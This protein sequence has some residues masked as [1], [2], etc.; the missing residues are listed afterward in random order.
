MAEVE[1]ALKNSTDEKGDDFK[2]EHQSSPTYQQQQTEEELKEMPIS[3]N[4]ISKIQ[5][6]SNQHVSVMVKTSLD[7]MNNERLNEN[8]EVIIEYF[9][10]SKIDGVTLNDMKKREF[11]AP[12]VAKC[13]GNAKLNG[14]LMNLFAKLKQFD[15]NK[16]LNDMED[17]K[18]Q[19]E[20]TVIS[21][22]TIKSIRLRQKQEAKKGNWSGEI[23]WDGIAYIDQCKKDHILFILN[24][25]L[26]LMDDKQLNEIR[27]SI[28]KYFQNNNI[29]GDAWSD[30][31]RKE[32]AAKIIDY[33]GSNKKSLTRP[34]L[35]LYKGINQFDPHQ[36]HNTD[37]QQEE[38]EEQKYGQEKEHFGRN[39]LN[40]PLEY[41]DDEEDGDDE[42]PEY[43]STELKPNRTEIPRIPGG[44]VPY[45]FYIYKSVKFLLCCMF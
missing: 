34:L 14:P 36:M 37:G 17:T 4:G 44:M 19:S 21:D 31:K 1:R 7:L 43:M 25:T 38:E 22:L 42:P 35:L 18:H 30:M 40:H 26:D 20:P 3:W 45:P 10:E 33:C 12:I 39:T 15:F 24:D 8:R 5:Q 27:D 28:V 2:Q 11:T 9:I 16:V 6:C 23:G 13:D 32:F 29:D 41:S